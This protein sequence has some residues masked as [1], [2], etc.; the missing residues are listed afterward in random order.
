MPD[1]LLRA[2]VAQAMSREMW[3]L[4]LGNPRLIVNMSTRL[5]FLR[6]RGNVLY[7]PLVKRNMGVRFEFDFNLDPMVWS[8]YTSTY[9]G[10]VVMMMI[11]TLQQG[12]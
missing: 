1:K 11:S 4:V 2:V 5:R 9:E 6:K 3:P 12:D 10:L 8:M 7:N